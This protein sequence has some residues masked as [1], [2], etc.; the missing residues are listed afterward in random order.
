MKTFRTLVVSELYEILKVA[1]YVTKR[2]N[3]LKK[4]DFETQ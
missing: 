2:L 4:R 1:I 3:P